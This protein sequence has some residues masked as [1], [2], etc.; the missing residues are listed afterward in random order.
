M[1]TRRCAIYTR[2]SSEEGLEQSF[3]SLDAQREACAAYIQS[4]KSEGWKALPEH[5]ND[6]GFSG[7]TMDR[8]ALSRLLQDIAAG[9]VD[10][11]V[12]YK[13][14]RLTRALSDFAKIVE[15]FDRHG[16]S[17]VSVT[18]AFNTT[19][20]MGRLTLN[21]LL[22]FAQFEREVTGERIRDKIAASKAKGMWM[23]GQPPLG[24]DAKDRKLIVVPEEAEKVRHIFS[25]YLALRSVNALA[26]E[27]RQHDIGSKIRRRLDGRLYGGCPFSRGALFHLLRN[28]VY[29]GE[30]VHKK[31]T[32]PGMHEA[33]VDPDMFEKVEQQLASSAVRRTARR[34]RSAPLR[35]RI[36]DA[37]GNRMTPCHAYGKTGTKYRY[38]AS[39]DAGRQAAGPEYVSRVW[40]NPIEELVLDRLRHL[41]VKPEASWPELINH[42][43]NVEVRARSV[44]LE[45]E[46]PANI[47]ISVTSSHETKV[48]RVSDTIVRLETRALMQPR[49]G[50]VRVTA[51]AARVSRAHFDRP[52]IAALRRAHR[53]L[54]KF[55]IDAEGRQ[56][57]DQARGLPDPYLRRVAALAF[58]APDIQASILLGRQPAGLTLKRA[59]ENPLPLDWREQRTFLGFGFP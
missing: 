41:F 52:L 58:L 33:I 11:V 38:Y 9:R 7:G 55:G 27:L 53:E 14:D 48:E 42:V 8:P 57:L 10:V 44:V 22:S 20:S 35:G 47:D 19:S 40:A 29:V 25:R 50:S 3:N 51:P 5:Y 59:T 24:Y 31:Q 28:R 36:F 6:G 26:D 12:V 23:G 45:I 13:V 46:V 4:Q 34:A 39:A 16:V 15:I 56:N 43:R 2:K 17:F 1:T 21:V 54:G 49:K 30:I 18:Q 37:V 32:Y